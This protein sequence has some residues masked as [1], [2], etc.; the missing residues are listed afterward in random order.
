M[1]VEGGVWVVAGSAVVTAAW[2]VTGVAVVAETAVV[3]G[4]WVVTGPAVLTGAW[5]VA[6]AAVV[7]GAAVLTGARLVAEAAVVTG[8]AGTTRVVGGMLVGVGVA[9]V[10]GGLTSPDDPEKQVGTSAP[11]RCVKLRKQAALCHS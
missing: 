10:V 9:V 6:E 5:L 7:T 8:A 2:V 4:A 1:A 11:G 3:T